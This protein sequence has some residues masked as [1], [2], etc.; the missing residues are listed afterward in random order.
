MKDMFSALGFSKGTYSALSIIWKLKNWNQNIFFR[1]KLPNKIKFMFCHKNIENYDDKWQF[2]AKQLQMCG[3]FISKYFLRRAKR[4]KLW[5][6][7]L[8]ALFDESIMYNLD[9][10]RNFIGLPCPSIWFRP[11]L[12]DC[13]WCNIPKRETIYQMTTEYT[14]WP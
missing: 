8:L 11:G 6:F 12:P 5:Q 14:K 4:R 7:I 3:F 9:R 13:S 1:A 10:P 2:M